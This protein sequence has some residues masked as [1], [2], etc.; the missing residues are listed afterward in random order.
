MDN[1]EGLRG[2]KDSFTEDDKED[3]GHDE[4]FLFLPVMLLRDMIGWLVGWS[5]G[6]FIRPTVLGSV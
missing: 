1:V 4:D 2:R 6:C 3:A 5:I